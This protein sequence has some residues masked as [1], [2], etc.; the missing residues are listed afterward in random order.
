MSEILQSYRLTYSAI[1]TVTDEAGVFAERF[2]VRLAEMVNREGIFEGMKFRPSQMWD[3]KSPLDVTDPNSWVVRTIQMPLRDVMLPGA[4]DE[5]NA[6]KAIKAMQQ[7]IIQYTDKDEQG[8]KFWTSFAFIGRVTIKDKIISADIEPEVW[9]L[10][11]DFSEGFRAYE[12]DIIMQMKSKFAMK[13]YPYL[14]RQTDPMALT[15]TIE[16][17]KTFLG[18]ENKYKRTPDFIKYCIE[19]AKRELDAMSPWTFDYELLMKSGKGRPAISAIRFIPRHQ[20]KFESTAKISS[21]ISAP[22]HFGT[23]T[24]ATRDIMV[25]KFGITKEKLI[26]YGNLFQKASKVLDLNVFAVDMSLELDKRRGTDREVGN[27]AGWF[28]STLTHRIK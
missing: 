9:R 12:L 18:V 26:A 1:N 11:L 15:M 21:E 8:K 25:N 7:A 5:T 27:P 19:P 17:C 28:I 20:L 4:E 14:C 23:Y 16:D 3:K 22:V 24:K 13:L 2:I 6:K 10:M